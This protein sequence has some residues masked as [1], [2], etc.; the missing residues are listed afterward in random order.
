GCA[1]KPPLTDV[2][3]LPLEHQWELQSHI[4]QCVITAERTKCHEKYHEP[5]TAPPP[6]PS[7]RWPTPPQPCSL[8]KPTRNW[9]NTIL[10][11]VTILGCKGGGNARQRSVGHRAPARIH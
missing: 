10:I 8:Y 7:Q 2:E 5:L 11:R 3:S 4:D 6:S 9:S 1:R